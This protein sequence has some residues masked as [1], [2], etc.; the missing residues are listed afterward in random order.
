MLTGLCILLARAAVVFLACFG[1]ATIAAIIVSKRV[2]RELHAVGILCDRIQRVGED[3]ESRAAASAN[4]DT[5]EIV[6]PPIK[7]TPKSCNS[8]ERQVAHAVAR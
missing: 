3:S 6:T 4:E 7:A 5:K 8:V 1:A 2:R